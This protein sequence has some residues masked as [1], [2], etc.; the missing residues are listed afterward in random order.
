M[1][2]SERCDSLGLRLYKNIHDTKITPLSDQD[3]LTPCFKS[4]YRNVNI[5][6]NG[7][8]IN[9]LAT[10]HEKVVRATPFLLRVETIE[11]LVSN[12]LIAHVFF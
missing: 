3:L 12:K 4:M 10:L 2:V 5:K 6:H 11:R 9:Y 7:T 1:K 8:A